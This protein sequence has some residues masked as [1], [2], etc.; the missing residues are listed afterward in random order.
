MWN[1]CLRYKT[2]DDKQRPTNNPCQSNGVMSSIMWL[3]S[4]TLNIPCIINNQQP[5]STKSWSCYITQLTARF[6][7]NAFK[8]NTFKVYQQ[9]LWLVR[10]ET[11]DWHILSHNSFIV[12]V[13]IRSAS[14]STTNSQRRMIRSAFVPVYD[15]DECTK[16]VL[17]CYGIVVTARHTKV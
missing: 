11:Y 8:Y 4:K 6:S 7:W 12:I 9:V 13:V 5:L 14:E 10:Q 3:V 1:Y 15:T 2:H 16:V 17:Y